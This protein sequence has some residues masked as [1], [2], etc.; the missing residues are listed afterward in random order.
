M[1]AQDGLRFFNADLVVSEVL[2]VLDAKINSFPQAFL[3][4]GLHKVTNFTHRVITRGD[5]EHA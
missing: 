3:N 5:I 2:N 1:K 4:G